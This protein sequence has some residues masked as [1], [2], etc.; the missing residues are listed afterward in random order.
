MLPGA[1]T[2]RAPVLMPQP[3]VLV[4]RGRDCP[5]VERELAAGDEQVPAAQRRAFVHQTARRPPV[6]L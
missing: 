5:G 2:K 3:G 6:V 4:Q 1:Q